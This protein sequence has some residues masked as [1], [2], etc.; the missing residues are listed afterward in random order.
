MCLE[1]ASC[2][3]VVDLFWRRN[4]PSSLIDQVEGKIQEFQ[5]KLK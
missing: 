2:S 4:F 1:D 5:E 3:E